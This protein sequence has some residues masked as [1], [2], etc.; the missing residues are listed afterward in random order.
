MEPASLLMRR[1]GTNAEMIARLSLLPPDGICRLSSTDA[2]AD[3]VNVEKCQCC[4]AY[5]DD[6]VEI[7]QTS[8]DFV[9]DRDKPARRGKRLLVECLDHDACMI[10]RDA[11]LYA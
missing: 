10:R 9:R 11:L 5:A 3:W 4:G 8:I 2:V 1:F 6:G 7:V